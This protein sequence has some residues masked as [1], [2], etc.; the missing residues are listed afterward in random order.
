L[1]RQFRIVAERGAATADIAVADRLSGM[2]LHYLG[3][4]AE[5]RACMSR[6]LSASVPANR[7]VHTTHYGAD[8]RVGAYV[9][10]ARALWLQGFPD[11][12]ISA[13]QASVDEATAAG[14]ANS[15]CLALA[16]GASLIATLVDNAADI[17][18]FGTMLT[19]H[20]DKHVLGVW[21]TYGAAL[22]GRLLT[23]RGAASMGAA[24]L[25]SALADLRETPLDIRYQLYL[26]WFAEALGKAGKFA[27]ALAAVDEALERAERTEERWYF[28]ELWRIR[29]ELL[30][31]AGG[32]SSAVAA[33]EC[34]ATSLGWAR[35]QETLS[36]EL[37]AATSLAR[38]LREQGHS[39]DAVA[40]LQPV[41]YRFT[42]GFGTT[43]L[44]AAKQLLDELGTP[45]HG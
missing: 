26:V 43:D 16:D 8:Q 10:L 18:R 14:H 11:Q 3:D 42:E 37:R 31:R 1:A 33:G 40:V 41:Y 9:L 22:R 34:F 23:G 27:E 7:H 19:E 30:L 12:A 28:P 4:Q 24:L 29:G 5:T 36:W 17:E 32:S 2:A 25:S 39:G 13:A 35:R 44:V 6:C 45:D 38:L 20:A 15:M 21:R